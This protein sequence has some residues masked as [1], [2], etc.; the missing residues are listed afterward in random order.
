MTRD[1]AEDPARLFDADGQRLYLCGSEGQRFLEAAA[2]AD[3]RTGALCRLLAYTGCR[4]SE[5]LAVTPRRLDAEAG[6]IIFRTLKRR[7]RTYRAV[8]IPGFLMAELRTIACDVAGDDQPLW[9]WCRQT[10]WRRVKKIMARAAITGPQAVPKSLRHS[11]G[12]RCAEHGVPITV[13]GRWMGHASSRST[14][15]YQQAVGEEER[16]FA[17]RLWRE[18]PICNADGRR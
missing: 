9:P 17:E 14:S 18:D 16:R 15:I 10:G 1:H 5:A 4:I 3:P 7:R 2:R 13:A 6:L 11:F 12:L 8:P